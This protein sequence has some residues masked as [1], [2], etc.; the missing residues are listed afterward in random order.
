M[1]KDSDDYDLLT[2][3]NSLKNMGA[4]R[5]GKGNLWE[6]CSGDLPAWDVPEVDYE[7]IVEQSILAAEA[8]GSLTATG[9]QTDDD[10]I[11]SNTL[12]AK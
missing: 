11:P 3:L 4:I 10:Q 7:L 9:D 6:V 1:P 5:K 12:R 2:A 8:L